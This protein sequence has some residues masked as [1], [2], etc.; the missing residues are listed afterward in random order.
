MLQ[1]TNFS[2][3]QYVKLFRESSYLLKLVSLILLVSQSKQSASLAARISKHSYVKMLVS[4][5]TTVYYNTLLFFLVSHDLF[6]DSFIITRLTPQRHEDQHIVL[7]IMYISIGNKDMQKRQMI[8]KSI[9]Y[10]L[11]GKVANS[12]L[13]LL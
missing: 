5:G 2:Y 12:S 11:S 8:T 6:F 3:F 10:F 9:F 4:R 1:L 13:N 7:K